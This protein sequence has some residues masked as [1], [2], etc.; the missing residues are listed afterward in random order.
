M[1]CKSMCIIKIIVV[2]SVII[3]TNI[4]IIYLCRHCCWKTCITVH[5]QPNYEYD[6]D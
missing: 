5:V 4:V 2:A 6:Y 1:T 3:I